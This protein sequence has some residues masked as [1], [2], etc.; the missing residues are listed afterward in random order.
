MVRRKRQRQRRFFDS[1]PSP[2]LSLSLSRTPPLS[3]ALSRFV[4]TADACY[5]LYLTC[6]QL[7]LTLLDM[8]YYE[9]HRLRWHE[10]MRC[11]EFMPGYAVMS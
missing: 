8:L 4:D 1:P 9:M 11:Y 5:Q 6:Y 7:Y 3:L 2:P 10:V